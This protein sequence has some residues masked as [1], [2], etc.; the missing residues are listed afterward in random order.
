MGDDSNRYNYMK[1]ALISEIIVPSYKHMMSLVPPRKYSG[2]FTNINDL[3][4]P[5]NLSVFTVS[6]IN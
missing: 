6:M 1:N 4:Q 3:C 2:M 5:M